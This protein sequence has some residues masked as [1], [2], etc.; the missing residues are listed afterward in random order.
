[1]APILFVFQ[2]METAKLYSIYSDFRFHWEPL[3]VGAVVN[4]VM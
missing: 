2:C 3:V 4:V 1:M